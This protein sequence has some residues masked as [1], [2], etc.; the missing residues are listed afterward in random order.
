MDRV[1]LRGLRARGH[2][3]VF[4]RE[5]EEGQTF[6]MDLVLGLDTREYHFRDVSE[7]GSW[8]PLVGAGF[9]IMNF[10]ADG[11]NHSEGVLNFHYGVTANFGRWT[12]FAEH[13]GVDLFD[14]NRLLFGLRLAL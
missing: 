5:R 6:I 7:R 2:H 10:N 14:L 1:A 13:Q 12:A 9:G 3:G 11:D 8:S 4:P